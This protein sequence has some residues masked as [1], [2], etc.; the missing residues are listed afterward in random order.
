MNK[1]QK[2][3]QPNSDSEST[4]T[5]F[6]NRSILNQNFSKLVVLPKLALMNCGADETAKINIKLVQ[7]KQEKYLKLSLVW[8]TKEEGNK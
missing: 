7:E 1:N 2:Q 4:V 6:G 3:R 5:D 8:N